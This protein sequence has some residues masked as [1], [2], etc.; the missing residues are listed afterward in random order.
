MKI[1]CETGET[2]FNYKE[3]LK[4]NHW[5]KKKYELK[6]KYVPQCRICQATTGLNVHHIRYDNIGDEKLTDLCYL[7][8]KCHTWMHKSMSSDE[9]NTFL[10]KGR[11]KAIPKK[12]VKKKKTKKKVIVKKK[13]DKCLMSKYMI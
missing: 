3:Y 12:K 2:V 9:I 4:T 13:V 6:Q 5:I 10:S 11:N 7:C 1:V 8:Y